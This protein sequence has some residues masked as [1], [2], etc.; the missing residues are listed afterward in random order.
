[1]WLNRVSMAVLILLIGNS[2]P[3]SEWEE[4]GVIRNPNYH[5]IDTNMDGLIIFYRVWS[6]NSLGDSEPT[7]PKRKAVGSAELSALALW[8][9][10][11]FSSSLNERI[12]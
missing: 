2:A 12:D 6:G 8:R 7:P 5:F 9:L 10:E 4:T 11:T 3:E 1:M